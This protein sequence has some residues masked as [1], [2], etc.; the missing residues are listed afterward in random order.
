MYLDAIIVVALIVASFGWFRRFSKFIYSVA[1]IDMFLR[2]INFIANNIGIK[3]FDKWVNNVFPNSIPEIIDKYTNGIVCTIIEWVYIA[4][5][6][7]F[8]F[9]TIRAFV[10]KKC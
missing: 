8:L 2:L 3:G 10:R 9:Y 6:V 7:F 4:I 5:M 1:I